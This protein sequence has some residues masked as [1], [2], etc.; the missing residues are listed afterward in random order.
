M[1]TQQL[2]AD[3]VAR[4]GYWDGWTEAQFLVRQAVKLQEE[5]GEL[6]AALGEYAPTNVAERVQEAAFLARRVFRQGRGW[7]AEIED[8]ERLRQV[9]TELADLQVV[10]FNAAEVL[11]SLLGEFVDVEQ[12]AVEKARA[13]MERGVSDA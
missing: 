1:E 10:L 4:R 6:F 8:D 9:R 13:D 12:E 5:L 7:P 2:V 3:L 11:G